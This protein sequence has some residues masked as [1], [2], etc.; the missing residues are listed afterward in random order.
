MGIYM[1]HNILISAFH[2][3]GVVEKG[4][5][6]TVG[7]TAAVFIICYL[8]IKTVMSVPFACYAFTGTRLERANNT[9]NWV[10]T[11][12]SISRKQSSAGG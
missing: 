3:F 5:T 12:K 11:V 10:Y 8:A 4:I 7:M 9:C 1:M 6:G 2:Y